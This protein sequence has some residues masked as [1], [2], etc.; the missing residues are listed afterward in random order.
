MIIS[1]SLRYFR[2]SENTSG[3]SELKSYVPT[4]NVMA[5]TRPDFINICDAKQG[6]IIRP[7]NIPR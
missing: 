4:V 1:K 5:I 3:Y 6:T 2:Q 7:G